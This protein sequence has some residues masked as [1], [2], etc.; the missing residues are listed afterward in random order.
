MAAREGTHRGLKNKTSASGLTL[1]RVRRNG[2]T[3]QGTQWPLR[4][5]HRSL[6]PKGMRG[7]TGFLGWGW[8]WAW[9]P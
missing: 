7:A 9:Q 4:G 2:G 6:S 8:V 5:G 1:T 3:R